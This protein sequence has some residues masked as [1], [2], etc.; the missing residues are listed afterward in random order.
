M[1]TF[2]LFRSGLSS[3]LLLV[4]LILPPTGAAALEPLQLVVPPVPHLQAAAINDEGFLAGLVTIDDVA[5]LVLWLRYDAYGLEAGLHHYPIP[6]FSLDGL[7][8]GGSLEIVGFSNNGV[9]LIASSRR[10]TFY[11]H[12]GEFTQL[13]SYLPGRPDLYGAFKITPGGLIYGAGWWPEGGY[14]FQWLRSEGPGFPQTD[15]TYPRSPHRSGTNIEEYTTEGEIPW[16]HGN[17]SGVRLGVWRQ[18]RDYYVEAEGRWKKETTQ[19]TGIWNGSF[20]EIP[21]PGEPT[22][23]GS[24]FAIVGYI[25]LNDKNQMVT[26]RNATGYYYVYLP[27]PDYNLPA[28]HHKISSGDVF[29]DLFSALRISEHG[30]VYHRTTSAQ[31][32]RGGFYS[33]SE[34]REV[35]AQEFI[36][37]GDPVTAER[38]FMI[39]GT[40]S[41]LV[42]GTYEGE[43]R[44]MILDNKIPIKATVTVS[45]K[46][47]EVGE[48][49][50]F[51]VAIRNT[52]EQPFVLT[53]LL[54]SSFR[55]IGSAAGNLEQL[56][57]PP[58]SEMLIS[59]DTFVQH[60]VWKGKQPGKLKF[61]L[62][63]VGYFSDGTEN[64]TGEI[65]SDEIQIGGDPV[66]IEFETL[67]LVP[68]N[69]PNDLE[70]VSIVNMKVVEDPN[71]EGQFL[72]I[73]DIP[74]EDD[75]HDIIDPKVKLTIKNEWEGK[76][77]VFATIQ[78]VDAR[79]RD[80]TPLGSRMKLIGQF[81][82][83]LGK[84]EYGESVE[85]E[86]NLDIR[87][88]GLFDFRAL[89]TSVPEGI[90]EQYSTSATGSPIAV[91]EPFPVEIE[92][93]FVRT[94]EITKN[95]N[96]DFHVQPGGRLKITAAVLNKT[97]GST[98]NFYGVKTEPPTAKEPRGNAFG[99]TLTS[100]EAQGALPPQKLDGFKSPLAHDH[101]IAP[102][103][104]VI[105]STTIITDPIGPPTGRIKWEIPENEQ[106]VLI[107]DATKEKTL[108]TADEILVS[109][110]LDFKDRSD[111]VIRIIQD[112]SLPPVT[113]LTGGEK[114]AIWAGGALWAMGPW[115]YDSVEGIGALFG[116]SIH[117]AA[118][119]YASD[120]PAGALRDTLGDGV[121]SIH[122][123]T[124]LIADTWSNMSESE[125]EEYI[126]SMFDEY[127]LR[128]NLF[129]FTKEALK[130]E[131]YEAAWRSFHDLTYGFYTSTEEAYASNDPIR[132]YD[133]WGKVT[134][135]I[136][137][138]V[139]TAF[140]P[141]P[142]FTK[143]A[144]ATDLSRLATNLDEARFLTKTEEWLRTTRG[145]VSAKAVQDFMGIG[146]TEL[147]R[148][149]RILEL[150]GMKGYARSRSTRATE[151]IE[152]FLEAL[153][154]PEKMK[155]KGF[156]QIDRY[157][158][159]RARFND[160]N[161]RVRSIHNSDEVLGL[162]GI[163][164]IFKPDS[165]EAIRGFI[166]ELEQETGEAL[167]EESKRAVLERAQ[168]RR[169][170]F[171]EYSVKFKEWGKPKEQGGGLPVDFN[172]DGNA[173]KKP[174][175]ILAEE[176]RAFEANILGSGDNAVIVPK[177]ADKNGVL[178]YITGDVDWI[179]FSWLDGTPLDE[180]IAGALYTVL[181]R[182][183][184]LQH[185]E[186]ISWF[187]KG[188]TVFKGKA[189]QL[190]D[191]IVGKSALLEV[192]G[193]ALRMVRL[194]PRLS[195]LAP[196]G[197][198]HIMFFD[199]GTKALRE[200][201]KSALEINAIKQGIERSSRGRYLLLPGSW[202]GSEQELQQQNSST[203]LSAHSLE[204]VSSASVG[205]A[206]AEK[207]W[208]FR[209][210]DNAV[211]ARK[212][213]YG[214]VEYFD[215]MNWLPWDFNSVEGKLAL[216]P[217]TKISDDVSFGE[218]H[219]EI[220]DLSLLA[221]GELQGHV[222]GWFEPGHTVIIAP[223][224]NTQEIR[225]IRELGTLVLETPLDF[226][227]PAGTLVA[228]LPEWL[229]EASQRF[230]VTGTID[231]SGPPAN[232]IVEAVRE[233]QSN[234]V[235]HLDGDGDYA[236]VDSLTDLSG[237]EITIQYWFKGESF[238]SA[239]RQQGTG[240]TV[241]GWNGMHLLSNDG[242]VDGI[243]V[244]ENVADGNWHHVAMTWKQ[245]TPNG[246]ASYLDGQLVGRRDSS[247]EPIPNHNAPL[248]FGAFN[249]T[250]EFS[251][252]SLDEI[253]IW[254]RTLSQTEMESNWN[255]TLSGNEIG[256]RGYWTFDDGAV[257]D[258]TF[259]NSVG[260]LVGDAF[261][262]GEING[263]LRTRVAAVEID[264]FGAFHLGN[265]PPGGGYFFS[266]YVDFNGNGRQDPD[267]LSAEFGGSPVM[268][269]GAA[270][271]IDFILEDPD[272][273]STD[274]SISY[275]PA[276]TIVLSWDGDDRLTLETTESLALPVQ[277]TT[278]ADLPI[279]TDGQATLEY[280][281]PEQ[282][283]FFRLLLP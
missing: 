239:V 135:N 40:G 279:V 150:F 30:E 81:P 130:P 231:Y 268:I 6:D 258:L 66:K 105:L 21:I 139:T 33:L 112:K 193:D 162:D 269:D 20:R 109:G 259:R 136:G 80:R 2:T 218:T 178:K 123:L 248:Y 137:L 85:E 215:G 49:F 5:N 165:D 138:E 191:F 17:T 278:V 224:E 111:P 37:P 170:E 18:V 35:L 235:L 62:K 230:A 87:D 190:V 249:G 281:L 280:D 7:G 188:Q 79:K 90:T 254:D 132:I 3:T 43:P 270:S 93:K 38:I 195:M 114:V 164:V 71:N 103:S 57:N 77:A 39:S 56:E 208:S 220:F 14:A 29:T 102:G 283:R 70:E 261:I 76:T 32:G 237:P 240:W 124:E 53:G 213:L 121:Q 133:N 263:F 211:M 59:G 148:V 238:H 192:T 163:T 236:V 171:E 106:V 154:K 166:R 222:D 243:S 117:G 116:E 95:G 97:S 198:N 131:E 54:A 92:L 250:S 26:S 142:N 221:E 241:A 127:L 209:N 153:G 25:D 8:Y 194:N 245:D 182:C 214:P 205:S 226:D 89:V 146:G 161:A 168:L 60:F 267:E 94:P 232:I 186:T 115:L 242:G 24:G 107:N 58:P 125:R 126:L 147:E 27:E 98:L 244:G 256:L 36:N 86:F 156:S 272:W 52:S 181:S 169:E 108:V 46:Q 51:D 253:A 274:L 260:G 180:H 82:K 200:L 176:P 174:S 203:M 120:D 140:A 69:P 128:R 212:D 159:G 264:D 64:L 158:M 122:N 96:G 45:S 202:F 110:T 143:Y 149:Q 118:N 184:N 187:L 276:G 210:S 183:C 28:G 13:L 144:T 157:V 9:V 175:G 206:G 233:R 252:G 229:R 273:V 72:V 271:N 84:I 42:D 23:T 100:L 19:L 275:Y 55:L 61:G 16:I 251:K 63:V 155:P 160:L 228:V 68:R 10:A 152:K 73:D 48:A 189:N 15:V 119:F 141:T 219:I 173:S 74:N 22:T 197:R 185:G 255:R 99:G 50:Y 201:R 227:H 225:V 223:G 88:D 145:P 129:F 266:A 199:A 134:T 91:G 101:E 257:T 44:T 65:I 172:Y 207:D 196:D 234:Q 151:L 12:R 78:G 177:M 217:I 113:V 31:G 204:G 1:K 11:W 216:S 34:G 83:D 246:F 247:N 41:I 265:L 179:H 75:L 47:V 104:S 282:T 67:P 4:S 167:S 277:W 262:D